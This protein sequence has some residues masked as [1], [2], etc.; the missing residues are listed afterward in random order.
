MDFQA[1]ELVETNHISLIMA[2][3]GFSCLVKSLVT[4]LCCLVDDSLKS[5]CLITMSLPEATEHATIR[6][7][8]IRPY[9]PLDSR[10]KKRSLIYNPLQGLNGVSLWTWAM[11]PCGMEPNPVNMVFDR[12]H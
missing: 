9:N 11:D 10:T 3:S 5:C 1:Q 12:W 7:N 6:M 8:L 4:L 2:A